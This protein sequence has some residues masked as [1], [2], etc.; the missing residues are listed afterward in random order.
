MVYVAWSEIKMNLVLISCNVLCSWIGV[1]KYYTVFPAAG[2][3]V[4]TLHHG[5][6]PWVVHGRT[7]AT[8]H[9]F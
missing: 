1:P 5:G 6:V 2:S 3:L 4:V 7:H 9:G 8:I